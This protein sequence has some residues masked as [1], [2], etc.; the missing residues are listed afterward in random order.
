MKK[1][2][3]AVFLI[4][5]IQFQVFGQG[6]YRTSIGVRGAPSSGLT[7]KHFATNNVSY[8]G[9]L[10]TRWGGFTLTGLYQLNQ[11][12]FGTQKWNFFYGV[13]GHVGYWDGNQNHPWFDDDDDYV[14][15]GIDG[16]IGLEFTFESIPFNASLDWKPA[17][18]IASYTGFWVD[19]IA[20]SLRYIIN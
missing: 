4:G 19:E 3:V 12:A 6:D 20:I 1:I 7:L 9:I 18:N 5:M 14:V 2:L 11:Q 8:E 16:I 13:G 10:S 17:F 15:A